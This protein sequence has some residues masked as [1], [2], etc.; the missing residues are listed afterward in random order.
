MRKK[1]YWWQ[2]WIAV[3]RPLEEV[4]A[5]VLLERASV[6]RVYVHAPWLQFADSTRHDHYKI[7][8]APSHR[9]P[10]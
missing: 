4:A 3:R 6:I 1:K 7:S 2:F 9:V 10:A 8:E 5:L